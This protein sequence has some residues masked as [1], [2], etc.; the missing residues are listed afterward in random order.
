MADFAWA[1]RSILVR[2]TRKTRS[3]QLALTAALLSL[4][5]AL[6]AQTPQWKSFASSTD[7]FQALF[8]SE[9]EVSKNSVPAGGDTYELRS[10]VAE[11]GSTALYIGVCDYGAKGA[12]ADPDDML[13]RAE[14]GAVEHM[15]AHMLSEKKINLDTEHED[16]G[17]GAASHTV[18]FEA[19]SDQ[20][21]FTVRMYMAGGVLYQAMVTSPLNEKFAD[22]AR[23]LDSFQLLPRQATEA[24]TPA[25]AAPGWKPYTYPSDGFSASFP[26]A[27]TMQ[28]QNVTTDA[29]TLEL[30]TYVAED[31]SA[32]F[33]GAVCD[34]GATAAG[35]DAD[36]LLESAQKGAIDNLKAHLLSEKK[37]ALGAN[38]GVEFEADS[39]TTH[40]S[41]RIY[42]AGTT[43]YQIIV[44]GP[45]NARPADTSRFL[46]SFQLID[47][48]GK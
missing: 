44:A 43:L 8:P 22:K 26:S 25:A 28:K 36:T 45:L 24:A 4:A 29:G 35:K 42:L 11:A 37:I 6:A 27:P 41:A 17:H 13:S 2:T 10:Y 38:H 23:F 39:D 31:S 14:K 48:T 34:Y 21:H 30:R 16:S 15:G 33:I 19:A 3:R 12:A 32:A 20:M 1:G 5:S 9:P 40:I 47:R 7:G 46:D 18:E